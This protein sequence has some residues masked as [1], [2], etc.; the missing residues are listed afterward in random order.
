[1]DQAL[2]SSTDEHAVARIAGHVEPAGYKSQPSIQTVTNAVCA[3]SHVDTCQAEMGRVRGLR[4]KAL[5]AIG[6]IVEHE[7]RGK[8]KSQIRTHHTG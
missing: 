3:D 5:G 7:H 8:E 1:M 4:F 2:T 6:S